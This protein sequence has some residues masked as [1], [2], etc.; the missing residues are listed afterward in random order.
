MKKNED[1]S[2]RLAIVVLMGYCFYIAR[3]IDHPVY[4]L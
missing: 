3:S 1:D 2:C 4:T